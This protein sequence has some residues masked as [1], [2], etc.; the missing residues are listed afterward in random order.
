MSQYIAFQLVHIFDAMSGIYTQPNI[1]G[2]QL[3]DCLWIWVGG[4]VHFSIHCFLW[5][6]LFSRGEPACFG[7]NWIANCKVWLADVMQGSSWLRVPNITHQMWGYTVFN[8]P[9]HKFLLRTCFHA[10][11]FSF[12]LSFLLSFLISFL[13]HILSFHSQS[14]PRRKSR[15]RK[16]LPCLPHNPVPYMSQG[17]RGISL[18]LGF[19]KR[20]HA[21]V[22]MWEFE[23]LLHLLKEFPSLSGVYICGMVWYL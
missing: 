5:H 16:G 11:I 20:L 23:S 21:C 4:L 14:L 2:K 1:D 12:V 6:H 8:S 9:N 18:G 3:S 13:H 7:D 19:K 17:F 10:F 22:E 15:P